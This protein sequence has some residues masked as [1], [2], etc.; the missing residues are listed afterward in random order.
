MITLNKNDIGKR[1]IFFEHPIAFTMRYNFFYLLMK[2][3]IT[4]EASSLNSCG[5]EHHEACSCDSSCRELYEII[6]IM[7]PLT[8]MLIRLLFHL[9]KLIKRSWR[10]T[11]RRQTTNSCVLDK[12]CD[13]ILLDS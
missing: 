11:G 8:F 7:R 13:E 6:E 9:T 1:I 5:T 12:S 4:D 2:S 10:E 3:T